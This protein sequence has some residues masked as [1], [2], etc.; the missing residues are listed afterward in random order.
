[1]TQHAGY[2]QTNRTGGKLARNIQ[3]FHDELRAAQPKPITEHWAECAGIAVA[4]EVTLQEGR[5]AKAGKLLAQA[6]EL[7]AKR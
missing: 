1:M 5:R 4:A 3:A 2:Q 7:W 6:K